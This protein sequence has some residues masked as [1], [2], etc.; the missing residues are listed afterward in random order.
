[1]ESTIAFDFDEKFIA[2]ETLVY[3]TL[4]T[5]RTN[6]TST[7]TYTQVCRRI[8]TEL[9]WLQSYL[10]LHHDINNDDIRYGVLYLQRQRCNV[11]ITNINTLYDIINHPFRINVTSPTKPLVTKCSIETDANITKRRI[12]PTLLI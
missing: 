7:M 10:R 2:I 8:Q 4:E 6:P 3:E 12:I 5:C 1:M 9:Q 11:L